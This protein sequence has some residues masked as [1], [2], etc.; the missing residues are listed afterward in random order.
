MRKIPAV[1]ALCFFS[2]NA[3]ALPLEMRPGELGSGEIF[4]QAS[5]DGVS[6][7]IKFDTGA[8]NTQLT[9]STWNSAYPALRQ[10]ER[11]GASGARYICD[12]ISFNSVSIEGLQ[13]DDFEADRC[14]LANGMELFA[15]NFF[16]GNTLH[17]DFQANALELNDP[18]SRGTF[19]LRTYSEGHIAIE[20][21]IG[22]R[23]YFAVFDTG[24]GLS[25]VD[26]LF[27]DGN[28][29][30]FEFVQDISGGDASGNKVAMKLY[31]IKDLEVK[32]VQ[33]SGYYV[34]AF[35]FGSV[36]DY[37]GK[38][39]PLILGFNI[40]TKYNWTLDLTNNLWDMHTGPSTL[41]SNQR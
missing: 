15:L 37:F 12:V 10:V 18:N 38:D 3:F 14:D 8:D 17:F 21:S 41:S 19:P 1:V 27:V 7:S 13:R 9:R 26:Q 30:A 16:A 24:A 34:L 35:D 40:I 25:S 20:A 33:L 28:P 23:P 6:R 11:G 32:G 5:F 29:S 36:R 22:G 2:W 31:K 39:T 4:I